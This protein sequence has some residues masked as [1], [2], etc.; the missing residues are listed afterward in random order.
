MAA[1]PAR[2]GQEA[3]RAYYER[4]RLFSFEQQRSLLHPEW[5]ARD[6]E[7]LNWPFREFWNEN[8]ETVKAAQVFDLQT[9]LPNDILTKVDRASMHFGVEA[10]VPLLSHKMVEFALSIS[11][12]L[13]RRGGRRKHVLKSA[14]QG[15][16]PDA[17]LSNRKRGFSLPLES[18][19]GQRLRA[20]LAG[21]DKSV[22]VTDGVISR[23]AAL[24][25]GKSLDQAWALYALD[26]WWSKWGR[27]S[28]TAEAIA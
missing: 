20:W 14:I 15:R 7:E 11:T 24:Q 21:M 10:R 5:S 28:G 22:L 17:L 6:E 9:Y 4:V 3:W 8:L 18:V 1:M 13:H 2:Y 27:G 19:V 12:H 16:V 25:I 23:D 26:L